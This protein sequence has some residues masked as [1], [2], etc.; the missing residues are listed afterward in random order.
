MDILKSNILFFFILY[1][2]FFEVKYIYREREEGRGYMMG[3]F[4]YNIVVF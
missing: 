4:F 2:R 1:C 3:F